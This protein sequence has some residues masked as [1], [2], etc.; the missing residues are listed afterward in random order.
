MS[1]TKETRPPCPTEQRWLK[2]YLDALQP[3]TP[4]ALWKAFSALE[5]LPT[6]RYAFQAA[7]VYSSRIEGNTLDLNSYMRSKVRGEQHPKAK[8]Q[9]EIDDLVAAYEFARSHVL[10]EENLLKAHGI[11]SRS[12]LPESQQGAYRTGRMFVFDSRG[13][14]YAAVEANRVEE[15]MQRFFSD[16]LQL[17]KEELDVKEAFYHAALMHLVFVHIHPMEDGNGRAARLLEK[18]FLAS[19][20]G[21]RAWKIPSEE[22]YWTHR[23]EYYQRIRLGP[24]FYMLDYDAGGSAEIAGHSG[25]VPFLK[26]LPQALGEATE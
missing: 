1:K 21:G 19:H 6:A 12:T 8:E 2:S 24:N 18:W 4:A 13:I 22:Y 26:L 7:S 11:L 23:P 10:N 17:R 9:Q 14:I 25:C 20:L 3:H 15:E 16:V 5:D